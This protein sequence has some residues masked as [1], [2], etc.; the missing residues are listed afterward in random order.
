MR[1]NTFQ[2]RALDKSIQKWE[3]VVVDISSKKRVSEYG[4]LD[5]E[6]CIQFLHN[7]L[8]YD[9][10][11]FQY[12]GKHRC[13]GTPYTQW[14]QAAQNGVKDRNKLLILAKN[15]LTFLKGIREERLKTTFFG[16]I[17]LWVTSWK[18]KLLHYGKAF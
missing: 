6:C 13:L 17:Y 10:P 4:R 3:K 7:E 12:T 2:R 11:I 5:C 9:C 14:S 8:C 1:L 18:D 16:K 15:E